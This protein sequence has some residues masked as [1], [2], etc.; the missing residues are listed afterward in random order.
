[1]LDALADAIL[2]KVRETY[3]QKGRVEGNARSGWLVVDYGSIVVH[4][5]A[6]DLRNYY[7][8]ENLWQEG[9]VVL[10]VQ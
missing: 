3:K 10:H 4:L 5:F 2:D 8:L 9:K 6:P 7:R 1:M